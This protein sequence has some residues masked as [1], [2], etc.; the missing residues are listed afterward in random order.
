MSRIVLAGGLLYDGTGSVPFPADILIGN[1][2]ILQV[3]PAGK[4]ARRIK[5]SR[6]QAADTLLE[7]FRQQCIH[8]GQLGGPEFLLP[9]A[10]NIGAQGIV[11]AEKDGI[12]RRL[13]RGKRRRIGTEIRPVRF[14]S[15]G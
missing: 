4:T 7:G 2:K 9:V 3:E 5:Q 14:D 6:G 11:A 8:G 13:P 1:D 10:R 15:V 12:D